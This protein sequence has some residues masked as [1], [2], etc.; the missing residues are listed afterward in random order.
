ML[1][2][3]DIPDWCLVECGAK[4]ASEVERMFRV[5]PIARVDAVKSPTLLLLGDSDRR[6]PNS[7]GLQWHYAL[8]K[9][10]VKSE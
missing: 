3:T 10:G 2:V 8:K 7:Q 4:E 5:S 1:G 9:N 6:V